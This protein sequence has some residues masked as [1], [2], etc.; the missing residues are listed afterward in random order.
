[1]TRSAAPT[2]GRTGIRA[3]ARLTVRQGKRGLTVP[4]EMFGEPPYHLQQV[5]RADTAPLRVLMSGSC[6]GPLGG[7]HYTV[8]VDVGRGAVLEFGSAAAAIALPSSDQH[9]S[10]I[11][12]QIHVDTGGRLLWAPQPTIYGGGSRHHTTTSIELRDGASLIYRETLALGLHGRLPAIARSHIRVTLN[13]KPLWDQET[14][15][16][17]E[18]PGSMGP[19]ITAGAQVLQQTLLVRPDLWW[20]GATHDVPAQLLAPGS[21]LLPLAGGPALLISVLAKH[22]AEATRI[23]AK[24][25]T[26]AGL[27]D[28]T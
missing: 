7:D 12:T 6:A 17:D 25:L 2:V 10:H 16:G 22:V 4:T 24:G 14:A 15:L 26:L 8:D 21:C 19:A 5:G 1:M 9:P 18:V 13:G 11:A 27:T 23:S 20:H 28:T 3:R